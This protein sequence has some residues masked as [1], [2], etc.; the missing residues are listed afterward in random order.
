MKKALIIT[1]SIIG[2]LLLLLILIPV[3]FKD[4]I[5]RKVDEQLAKTINAEVN[6]D[7]DDIG[8]SLLR[9]FPNATASL[10]DFSIVGREPFAG[11]TLLAARRFEIVIDLFSLFSGEQMEI[12][13]IELENPLIQI[14]VLEDGRANYDI[15]IEDETLSEEDT[16][17][18]EFN[19]GIDHW[20]I[21]NGRLVY[22]DRSIPVRI[23]LEDVKH[24][25]NG[26][27]T[28]DIFDMDTYTLAQHGYLTFDGVE[29][30]TNKRL[31][32]DVKMEMNLPEMKFTFKENTARLNDFAMH[33]DGFIAMPEDPIIFDMNFAGHENT[34]KDLLSV[35]PGMYNEEFE[36]IQA[37]G[38]ID[39]QGFYRGEYSENSMPGYRLALQVADARFQYEDLPAAVEN[40][41]V[42]MLVEDKDG[43]MDNLYVN[44]STF[45]MNMGNNPVEGRFELRS[46]EPMD[47]FADV[48]ARLNLGEID[49]ILKLQDLEMQGL[50]SMNLKADGV[51]DSL[52]NQFPKINANMQ[53]QD[54]Y[55]KSVDYD[56]PIRNF[57]FNATVN[58]ETGNLSQTLVQ[59]PSFSML[60][61]D[62]AFAGS[63]T[64][65]DLNDYKWDVNAEGTLDLATISRIVEFEDME[66]AGRIVADVHS[67][68]RMSALEAGRYEQL[69]TSG[70]MLVKDFR[71]SS[72]DMPHD[73]IIQ[74]AEMQ[75]NPRNMQLRSFNGQ[76]GS[77]D[78]QLNGTVSNYMGYALKDNQVLKGEFNM[79][80]RKVNL[81]EWMTDEEAATTEPADTAS[82]E[83]IEIPQNLDLR[84][85]ATISEVI[86]DNLTLNN[87]RGT[88]LVQNGVVSMRD[89]TFNTLGGA[90]GL[91]GTYDP[92]DVQNPAFDFDFNIK[93]LAIS[94]AYE[95]FVTVQALAP[96]ARK[97][98]GNFNTNFRLNGFLSQDMTPKM[99]TLTGRG[100]VELIDATLR[101]SETLQKAM[102][103][104]Q[105][106]Q[107]EAAAVQLKD[108]LLK[109]RV[110]DGFV[111]VDPF[112]FTIS[113]ITA[114]VEGRQGID[115]TL[116]YRMSLDVPAGA[117]GQAVNKLLAN[118]G[119]GSGAGSST[120]K[121]NLGVGGTYED[122]KVSLL[123]A[124]PGSTG[125]V[126]QTAREAGEERLEAEV[127]KAKEELEAKRAEAEAKAKA[128]LEE[129]RRQAEEEAKREMEKRQQQ[130]QDSLKNKSKGVLKDVFKRGGGN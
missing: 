97:M 111:H 119:A 73:F 106:K 102:N 127:D 36:K 123:G 20:E 113:N 70:T 107:Q 61:A 1:G 48:D 122:P 19:I 29:Y 45:N 49:Q 82:L 100:V 66:V 60:V 9:N 52:R 41:N 24:T 67:R 38:D 80:S 69:P 56:V 40:I 25:G 8:L 39:F 124:G 95:N 30:V 121:M 72:V 37:S 79:V 118:V 6:Y 112:D 21:N 63:I 116:D 28:Q 62:D 108:V 86:Y 120:I 74:T 10:A 43:T 129:K 13:A 104:T 98:D 57:N 22:E 54:G 90:F 85:T 128:E 11:D 81:N 77:T 96:V 12:K 27:F 125:N 88:L 92:R 59:A 75:F 26:D 109:A 130:L 110:E 35:V 4:Q 17:E 16:A 51:Y 15:A 89:L 126:A 32:A 94:R 87:M 105:G 65:E 84:F 68:G 44:V 31:E 23:L 101:N 103:F 64:L 42:N 2:V 115:G 7:S 14:L 18:T 3:F 34:F 50:F 76:I 46:L 114:T 47:I 5:F 93:D 71:Y 55:F 91:S 117:A 99:E 58:N 33:F 53:M 78:M 83:V